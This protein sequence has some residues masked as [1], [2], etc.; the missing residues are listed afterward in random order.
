MN[1]NPDRGEELQPAGDGARQRMQPFIRPGCYIWQRRGV[2]RFVVT[3]CDPGPELHQWFS[4]RALR[5]GGEA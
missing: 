4:E 1:T 2:V 3:G 5:E